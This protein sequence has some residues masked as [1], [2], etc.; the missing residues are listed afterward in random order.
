VHL[1]V[2]FSLSL[3]GQTWT[4]KRKKREKEKQSDRAKGGKN[5]VQTGKGSS[6][7]AF[8]KSSKALNK[9]AGGNEEFKWHTNG[10]PLN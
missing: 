4:R 7:I 8:G 2:D 1:K 5:P 9:L 6:W 3:T 10:L